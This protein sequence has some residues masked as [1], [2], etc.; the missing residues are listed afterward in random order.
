LSFLHYLLGAFAMYWLLRRSFVL[1]PTAA[2]V[3]AI[4]YAFGGSFLGRFSHQPVLFTLAWLPLA[5][6]GAKAFVQ[7]GT[8]RSGVLTVAAVWLMGVSSHPLFFLYGFGVVTATVVWF[9]LAQN[10]GLKWLALARGGIA[11]ALALGLLAPRILPLVE[12]ARVTERPASAYTIAHL[13]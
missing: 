9:S 12:L 1:G 6:G 7:A 2:M 3:G 5:V 13:F 4:S 8:L 10:R 11:L